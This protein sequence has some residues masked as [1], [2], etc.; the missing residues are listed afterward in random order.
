M[1]YGVLPVSMM[2]RIIRVRLFTI[3]STYTKDKQQI[4]NS[5]PCLVHM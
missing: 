2:T 3:M 1:T 4:W 5:L